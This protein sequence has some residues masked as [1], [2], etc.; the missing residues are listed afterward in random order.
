MRRSVPNIFVW[1]IF[2]ISDSGVSAN[3]TG[4]SWDAPTLFTAYENCKYGGK[5]LTEDTDIEGFC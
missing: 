1:M 4:I 3:G 2:S 5:G